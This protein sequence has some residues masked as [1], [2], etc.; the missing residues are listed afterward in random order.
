MMETATNYNW[1]ERLQQKWGVTSV[2]SV[3]AI[4]LTFTFSGSTVV[5]LRKGL[6]SL[7]NYDGSTPFWL[8]TITY[9]VF[10]FPTYQALLLI[11][12]FILGQFR[13]FWEKEKKLFKWLVG[14]IFAK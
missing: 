6:F 2:W 12:G 5:W 13:F 8:K 11:Y 3:I 7:L 14:K 1:I 4:L 9:L 10:I